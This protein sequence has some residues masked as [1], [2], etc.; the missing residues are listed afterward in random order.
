MLNRILV[1]AIG[2]MSAECVIKCLKD[3]GMYVVGCDMF[4]GLWHYET[5]L[6]DAFEQAPY[7]MHKKEYISFLISTCQKY[8]LDTILP[9]TDLEIDVLNIHRDELSNFLLAM[10]S[11]SVLATVRDKFQ[12]YKTF[13][14]DSEVP[15]LMTELLTDISGQIHYPCVAKPYNGRSSE[16]LILNAMPKD[17]E[18]IKSPEYYIVQEQKTGT[19]CTVDYVRSLECGCDALVAREELLRTKNG[20]G[21]V[22]RIFEDQQLS[23]LVRHIGKK[24]DVGSTINMEFIYANDDKYYLIDVNPRFSAGVAYSLIAGYNMVSNHFKALLNMPI[25]AEI[26]VKEQYIAKRLV[27]EVL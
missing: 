25:D 20:A 26:N 3:M 14:D 21:K 27:E 7:A 10:P 11:K 24:L 19:I 12:L 18:A 8:Q 22:V 16:G 13:C 2:S 9:L 4:P 17:L 5:K 6:C 23:K 15:S 1:T